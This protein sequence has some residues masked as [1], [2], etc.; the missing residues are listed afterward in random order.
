MN[1][2]LLRVDFDILSFLSKLSRFQPN[3]ARVNWKHEESK[4]WMIENT[5][6]IQN[7]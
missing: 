5:I 1:K 6:F 4:D 3:E 2:N 7:K